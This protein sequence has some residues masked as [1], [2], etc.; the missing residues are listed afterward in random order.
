[1]IVLRRR[2]PTALRPFKVPWYPVVPLVFIGFGL[3]YLVLTLSNDVT[4]Y[5]D[6]KARGKPA[7][8]NSALGLALVFIGTPIYFYYK[9]RRS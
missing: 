8:L 7:M 4:T 9:R 6:L 3:V 1:V 2:E 5:M